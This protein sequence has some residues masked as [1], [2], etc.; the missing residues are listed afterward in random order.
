MMGFDEVVV[1]ADGT[2]S[3]VTGMASD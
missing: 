2:C 1:H 3:G